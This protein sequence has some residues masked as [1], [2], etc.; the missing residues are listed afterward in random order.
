[1][2]E[3]KRFSERLALPPLSPG[4]AVLTPHVLVQASKCAVPHLTPDLARALPFH[5]V[6]LTTADGF[7]FAP[8]LRTILSA[9][10]QQQQEGKA[11]QSSS[12]GMVTIS[13]KA[14]LHSFAKATDYVVF[15]S[16]RDQ[17]TDA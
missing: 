11:E 17:L 4:G 6:T 3:V 15:M 9:Q 14:P 5:G 13:S 12:N 2:S 1:M 8:V 10:Q 7:H 16:L